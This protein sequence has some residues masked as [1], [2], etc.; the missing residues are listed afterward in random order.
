MAFIDSSG[1]E[2]APCVVSKAKYALGLPNYY[3]GNIKQFSKAYWEH[4]CTEVGNR[5]GVNSSTIQNAINRYTHYL[6]AI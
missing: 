2:L 6:L 1:K 3:K 5:H 4:V